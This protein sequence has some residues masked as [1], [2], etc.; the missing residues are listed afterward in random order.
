MGLL[1][2]ELAWEAVAVG[3]ELVEELAF[4]SLSLWSRSRNLERIMRGDWERDDVLRTNDLKSVFVSMLSLL[5]LIK[6]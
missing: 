1:V 3:E 4:E 2:E 5:F 6:C